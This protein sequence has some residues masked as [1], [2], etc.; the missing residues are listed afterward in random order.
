MNSKM[1]LNI[2]FDHLNPREYHL[3]YFSVKFS[4]SLNF[5]IINDISKSNS[6]IIAS[7]SLL[8]DSK[9]KFVFNK[10]TL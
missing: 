1:P 4:K 9:N 3:S 6:D 8:L 5:G 7:L 2:S 10:I